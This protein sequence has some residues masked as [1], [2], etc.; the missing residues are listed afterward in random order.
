MQYL[1]EAQII[2]WFVLS[3]EKNR[4]AVR[5]CVKIKAKVG[6]L[7]ELGELGDLGDLGDLKDVGKDFRRPRL[8]AGF[9]VE[10]SPAETRCAAPP[11]A[12]PDSG[13]PPR[14]R[15]VS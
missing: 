7:G 12:W 9:A 1:G 14:E 13:T 6:D 10:P 8:L 2:V 11:P 3:V 5:E 4:Q 15:P